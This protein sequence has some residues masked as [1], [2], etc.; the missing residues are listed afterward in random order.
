MIF[1]SLFSAID[2]NHRS[3]VFLLTILVCILSGISTNYKYVNSSGFFI[4]PVTTRSKSH[5]LLRIDNDTPQVYLVCSPVPVAT[6][7]SDQCPSTMYRSRSS[8]IPNTPLSSPNSLP[9]ATMQNSSSSLFF[10]DSSLKI[11]IS[12]LEFE[13]LPSVDSVA[14]DVISKFEK[15]QPSLSHNSSCLKSSNMEVDC[16][17]LLDDSPKSDPSDLQQLFASLSAT[18][19]ASFSSHISSQ[20]EVIPEQIQQNVMK[21]MQSQVHF[22]EEVHNELDEFRSLMLKQQQWME[23]KVQAMSPSLSHPP[24]SVTSVSQP[25][26]VLLSLSAPLPSGSDLQ[27]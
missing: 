8:G 13:N 1:P 23:S 11:S 10:D 6:P 18:L 7:T 26:S 2:C 27:S 19:L 3:L 12:H 21:L 5:L 4:M 24:P 14:M 9:L 22:K 16:A 17:E 15:S 20:T 25:V